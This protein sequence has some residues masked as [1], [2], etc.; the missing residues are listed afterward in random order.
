MR[1]NEIHFDVGPAVPNHPM[2]SGENGRRRRCRMQHG[3]G[4]RHSDGDLPARR[5]DHHSSVLRP[6]AT[7]PARISRGVDP[8][9]EGHRRAWRTGR[10]DGVENHVS[11]PIDLQSRRCRIRLCHRAGRTAPAGGFPIIAW[12]HGTTGFAAPCAPS[13]FTSSGGGNGPYLVPGLAGFL[14]A[15]FAIAAADYQGQGV[16]DGIHPYLVGSSEGRAVLDA[17]RATRRI[18]GLRT[19]NTVII[20][21][22]SQGGH[23]A[24]FA[25]QMAPDYAPDLHLVGVVAAAPAT[26]LS[27][28]ISIV[29]SPVGQGYLP[30]S[31]PVAYSWSH[32]YRDLP[33]T[34]ILTP[35][36]ERFAA[37]E[38]SAGC[39]PALANVI[40]SQHMT[41]EVAFRSS[42]VSNPAVLAHAKLNDP[43]QVRTAPPMLVLQGTADATV[44]PAL[45]DGFI[46]TK[47]CPIGDTVDY[48][49]VTG[50]THGTVVF[51]A[52]PTIVQWM[53]ARL[54][55]EP[56]P[57]TCGQ[58]GN[59]GTLS[60]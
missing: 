36:G 29:A 9:R 13:L 37:S 5:R 2:P 32:T 35:E 11:L 19:R 7:P 57:T 43:G 6:T 22:H 38:V 23:A 49:H 15:G 60:Q 41:P 21:G 27:T 55:G 46:T 42:A 1:R 28:L 31:I 33:S 58:P 50:A 47:A 8:N 59:L 12:A 53:T 3:M 4:A 26:G 56:A 25:G 48:L 10:G 16:A 20:Y 18:P 45:T 34:D 14:H 52:A 39:G 44:P 40:T 54:T 24:L 51:V 30:E 17:A